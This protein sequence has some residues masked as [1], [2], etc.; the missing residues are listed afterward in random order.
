MLY[1]ILGE[2]VNI[3]KDEKRCTPEPNLIALSN[4]DKINISDIPATKCSNEVETQKKSSTTDDKIE[5]QLLDELNKMKF[6]SQ[7]NFDLD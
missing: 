1:N 3:D 2:G 6:S 4:T 5:K 7:P